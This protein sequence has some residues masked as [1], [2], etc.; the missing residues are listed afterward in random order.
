M[1][2]NQSIERGQFRVAK[3]SDHSPVSVP[4]GSYQIT[5]FAPGFKSFKA[6]VAVQGTEELLPVGLSL[7]RL[8]DVSDEA[9]IIIRK[10]GPLS[11]DRVNWAKLV[12]FYSDRVFNMVADGSGVCRLGK[13]RPGRYYLLFFKNG[14]LSDSREVQLQVGENSVE[15]K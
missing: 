11:A 2:P 3:S 10:A 4:C 8:A 5:V 14:S 12:E 1:G 9:S 15:L 6:N 13:L 7:G